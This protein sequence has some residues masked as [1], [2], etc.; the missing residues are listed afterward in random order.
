MFPKLAVALLI[1]LIGFGQVA[2]AD[3]SLSVQ[4][5]NTKLRSEPSMWSNGVAS[6]SYGDPLT[7]ISGDEPWFKV[8]TSHG[9]VGFIPS[10]AVTTKKIVLSSRGASGA[11]S[12][13]QSDVVLAGKGFSKEAEAAFASSSKANFAEVDAVER[14]KVSEGEARQ[15]MQAGQLGGGK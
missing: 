2:R 15:F 4:V 1:G 14:V 8:K 7:K 5:R 9:Q 6:L 3:D 11:A 12:V 10:S 13:D